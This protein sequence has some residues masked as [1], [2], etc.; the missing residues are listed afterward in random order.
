MDVV[1]GWDQNAQSRASERSRERG[2]PAAPRAAALPEIADCC[3]K[4]STQALAKVQVRTGLG[5]V[6]SRGRQ[7]QGASAA[8]LA[9]DDRSASSM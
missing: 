1:S 3:P 2:A 9:G 5:Q 8:R 4:F 7:T 6:C